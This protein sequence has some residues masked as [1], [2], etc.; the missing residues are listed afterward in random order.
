[1]TQSKSPLTGLTL[2]HVGLIARDFEAAIERYRRLGFGEPD[3]VAVPDQGVRVATFVAGAGLVEIITPTVTEGG[4]VRFLETRGEGVHH[5]AYAV[6]DL[7][8]TLARLEAAGFELI[9]REPRSGAHGWR[10]AF[11]HPKSCGGVLTELVEVPARSGLSGAGRPL[12][13]S[14]GA[15]DDEDQARERAGD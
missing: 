10:I 3:I 5:V 11:V 4:M 9:D 15:G 8:E 6:S 1:M 13:E 2:H 14:G 7:P 12:G